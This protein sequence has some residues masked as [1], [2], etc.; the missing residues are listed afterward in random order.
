MTSELTPNTERNL[1]TSHDVRLDVSKPN[2]KD[3]GKLILRLM[4]FNVYFLSILFLAAGNNGNFVCIV[5][6]FGRLGNFLR[7]IK[8]KHFMKP[9]ERIIDYQ[10]WHAFVLHI[11][12]PLSLFHTKQ[13]KSVFFNTFRVGTESD[14][15]LPPV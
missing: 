4:L 2:V 1:N 13:K 5:L 11:S 9:L 15:P 10:H 7:I 12:K 6:R 3:Y 14:L 8:I